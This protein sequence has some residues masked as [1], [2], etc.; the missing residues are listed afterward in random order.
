M[1]EF[2][3]SREQ[4]EDQFQPKVALNFQPDESTS[5]FLHWARAFKGGGFNS[6]AFRPV[7]E[8]LQYGPEEA[9]EWGFDAKMTLFDG[10]ARWNVSLFRLDIDEFQV[11][12]RVPED[13]TLGLGV[14]KVE[15]AAKARAQGVES[16]F[17]W[18]ATDWLTLIATLGY[19]DTEY[20]DFKINDCP[21]DREDTDGDGDLRCDAT[22][23]PFAFAPKYNATLTPQ[24]T[25][26]VFGGDTQLSFGVTAEY[27]SEQ[28]LD[29]D[30]D[31]RK[32][33]EAFFRYRANIGISNPGRGWSFRIIGEN[34]TDEAT[35]IRQGDVV[36]GLFVNIQEPAR[37]IFGQFR[38]SF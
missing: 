9:Q 16:D 28:F 33:Q 27:Q 4:S 8:E 2:S 20:L 25:F 5:L 24:L 10:A 29:I 26:P 15:N 3:A 32:M 12:T 23:K 6:F 7:D 19:N 17:T 13:L 36:P 18:L 22:G 1:Q 31:E 21:A 30:L 37:Q 14:T 35:S 34:L 11:L 38:Y